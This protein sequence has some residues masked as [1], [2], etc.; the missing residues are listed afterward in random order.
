MTNKQIYFKSDFNA[1]LAFEGGW[2]GAPFRLKFYTNSPSRSFIASFDGSKYTNCSLTD[3]DR[4]LVAFDDHKLGLGA[5]MLAPEFYLTNDDFKDGYCNEFVVP[6]A[7][8]FED[9]DGSEYQLVLGLTGAS[10]I[11]TVG[12]LPAFYQKGDNATIKSYT[13]DEN[14]NTVITWNDGQTTVV[15]KGADADIAAAEAA[16]QRA[17]NAAAT[18]EADHTRAVSDHNTAVTDHTQAQSDHTRANTDH[19]TAAAD[20]TQAQQDHTTFVS[21]E[22]QRQ[23]TFT[24]SEQQRSQTFNTNEAQRQATF[25]ASETSRTNDYNT[26]EAARQSAAQSQRQAE[27]ATFQ[28]KEA[29]RDAANQ[30][31][32]NA[33]DELAQMALQVDELDSLLLGEHK[34][35]ET[36]VSC[37]S[38]EHKGV[39]FVYPNTLSE[40]TQVQARANITI[41]QYTHIGFSSNSEEYVS[42]DCIPIIHKNVVGE[43]VI[44]SL[45]PDPT[46]YPYI[47]VYK[48]GTS[49]TS[50]LELIKKGVVSDGKIFIF[51]QKI[52][53]LE[54]SVYGETETSH[55][56]DSNIVTEKGKI[57][58]SNGTNGSSSQ[59]RRYTI[60]FE[61]GKYKTLTAKMINYSDSGYAFYD[62]DDVFIKGGH[63]E[64]NSGDWET[65]DIP[66]NAVKFKNTYIGTTGVQT[67]YAIEYVELKTIVR[68]SLDEQ[69]KDIAEKQSVKKLNILALGNSYTL[70]SF[71]YLP[72]MAKRYGIRMNVV[73]YFASGMSLEELNTRFNGSTAPTYKFDNDVDEA[74]QTLTSQ[75]PKQLVSSKEWDIISIQQGSTASLDLSTYTYADNVVRK[76]FDNVLKP[77]ILAWN[78]NINRNDGGDNTQEA[79]TILT[80]IKSTIERIGLFDLILPY[81]TAIFNARTN[82]T[83]D[84]LGISGHLWGDNV[85]LQE[86]VPCYIATLANLEAIMRRLG[87]ASSVF[88]DTWRPTDNTEW[89]VKNP[90]NPFIPVTNELAYLSQRCAIKANDNPFAISSI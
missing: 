12:T 16:T 88:G 56:L 6:F 38:N 72:I 25:E 83:L 26:Q 82:A 57:V 15:K 60:G 5:L 1:I 21:N 35:D 65:I 42:A 28:S 8:V 36:I 63:G 59:F 4:L 68:K 87:I 2:T 9:T 76:I 62:V 22:Q 46:I 27:D 7:P 29:T 44:D 69:I 71:S 50:T 32:L 58:Y 86:G 84:A 23:A 48:L 79:N 89:D 54:K 75:T 78:V 40:G 33:A 55:I 52:S 47:Y 81:G 19:S 39:Y 70:D 85:H 64:G 14:G 34:E 13:F 17:N 18:S 43:Y 80:N 66:T 11:E 41:T 37:G 24:D 30:A 67:A 3:D 31:A 49:N 51:D 45:S 74:W 10:T 90:Q 73:I 61:E 77:C 20:H 53:N